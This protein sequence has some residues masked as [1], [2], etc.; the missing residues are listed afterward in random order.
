MDHHTHVSVCVFLCVYSRDVSHKYQHPS[1]CVCV[2]T[3]VKLRRDIDVCFAQRLQK[4]SP[5]RLLREQ[6]TG[7]CTLCRAA[8]LLVNSLEVVSAD[9]V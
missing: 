1:V 9:T 6:A 2:C 7:A 8:R 4:L 5:P 3:H